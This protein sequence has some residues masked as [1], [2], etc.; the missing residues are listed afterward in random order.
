M[1]VK[2]NVENTKKK[3]ILLRDQLASGY[4]PIEVIIACC[5]GR[6]ICRMTIWPSPLVQEDLVS[7]V[8]C[9]ATGSKSSHET[10]F[11]LNIR[12]SGLAT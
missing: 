11:V 2:N 5:N 6:L 12:K 4:D 8:S 1:L 3:N 7:A 10:H 9:L